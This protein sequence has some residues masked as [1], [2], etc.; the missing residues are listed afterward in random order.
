MFSSFFALAARAPGRQRDFRR[1]AAAH[2]ALL[3]ALVGL[4]PLSP[5]GGWATTVL[6]QVLLV[7]G[8]VEGAT[9]IGWRLTQLPKSQALEF[10]LV[11]PLR[12]FHVLLAEALVGVC[13]LVL[14]TLAGA[15]VLALLMAS[16]ILGPLDLCLFLLLP[17]TWGAITGL[18]LT[19][20]AYEAPAVRRWGERVMLLLV[21][22]YLVAGVLAGEK[23]Q[24][25]LMSLPES[26]G[27]PLYRGLIVFRDFNP[28]GA[29]RYWTEKGSELAWERF[30]VVEALSLLFLLLAALRAA[31]RLEPHFHERHYRPAVLRGGD[32]RG[33]IADRPL[34]WWAVRRVSEYSGRIN[35]WL[36]GGFAV[37]YAL[38]TVAGPH[39]PGW[40]GKG[41]FELCDRFLGVAGL[42]TALVVLAAVPAAF[43]YGLWD[44]SLQDRCRRLELLLLTRL[45]ARDYWH[46]AALAAWK[47]GRGYFGVAL[48]LWAAVLVSGQ[49]SFAR[50]LAAVCGGVL[51]WAL[52]FCLGFRSFSRG[53]HANGLGMLL[54]I[55][56][57]LAAGA[58]HHSGLPGLAALLPPGGIHGALSHPDLGWAAGLV[59][60]AA[61]ALVVAR[62]SLTSCD[63][64]LRRWYDQHHGR[65]VFT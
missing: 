54:T 25:W 58:L 39:W 38:Y 55:G 51:L 52:Y 15:P 44:A 42:A 37:L 63:A 40:M 34:T 30:M 18:L 12:P 1:L 57:P 41:V 3:T 45:H 32:E 36:A 53:T 35:L 48:V 60:S 43:Q 27:Y 19:M 61:L 49:A 65:K 24:A 7:A 2:V 6:G 50:V 62:R 22:I 59:L 20:W 5:R 4:L 46:A 56:L 10:L 17:L 33:R 9:L 8:I 31:W 47:R 29:M 14:V 64:H 23:L 16:G 11:S 28:F 13:F 26:V 21:L